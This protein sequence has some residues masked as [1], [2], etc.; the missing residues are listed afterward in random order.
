M[1]ESGAPSVIDGDRT[2]RSAETV[3]ILDLGSSNPLLSRN[4]QLFSC[5]WGSTLGTD[6]FLAAS[7]SSTDPS[8]PADDTNP[9]TPPLR[10][11]PGVDL[12]GTSRIKLSAKPVNAIPRPHTHPPTT[13]ANGIPTAP[14]STS[15]EASSSTATGPTVRHEPEYD[16]PVSIL[17]PAGA[18]TARHNQAAFLSKL[19]NIKRQRGELGDVTVMVS[20]KMDLEPEQRRKGLV[21]SMQERAARRPRGRPRRGRGGRVRTA[22]GTA[23]GQEPR[24]VPGPEPGED[25]DMDMDMMSSRMRSEEVLPTPARWADL[26]PDLEGDNLVQEQR[27]HREERNGDSAVGPPS[28]IRENGMAMSVDRVKEGEPER[29]ESVTEEEMREEP[30]DQ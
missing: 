8:S 15:V 25:M 29:S 7:Q 20:N 23:A 13:T 21:A 26:D 17:A 6:L 4:G 24:P 9:S 2:G 18:S 3:Q 1:D 27:V 19:V 10:S 30:G 14:E 16:P 22:T 11:L 12:L 5:T 28:K